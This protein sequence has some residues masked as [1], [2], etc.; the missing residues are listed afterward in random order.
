MLFLL[1]RLVGCNIV[2]MKRFL[3]LLIILFLLIWVGCGDDVPDISFT[4]EIEPLLEQDINGYYH[5]QIDRSQWQTIHRI[6]GY[7]I[8]E[9]GRPVKNYRIEWDSN[10]FWVTNDTLG[11]IV[12]LYSSNN[13]IYVSKDTSYIYSFTGVEVPTTNY[14]SSSKQSGEII[15][16]IS[17]VKSM[18]G[19]TMVLSYD[20]LIQTSFISIVLD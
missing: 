12:N 15:N 16:R 17:P 3:T 11:Y 20:D 18:I 7:V 9:D 14:M 4:F 19:D 13:G 5:L 1:F 6:S 10:L 8:T 2:I